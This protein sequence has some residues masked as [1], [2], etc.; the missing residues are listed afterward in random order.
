[1]RL[2]LNT[3]SGGPLTCAPS[4][5]VTIAPLADDEVRR[6]VACHRLRDAF[7]ADNSTLSDLGDEE[8]LELVKVPEDR[9]LADTSTSLPAAP[10]LQ[11]DTISVPMSIKR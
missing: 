4:T 8:M 9:W 6:A 5:P 7:V 2:S 3:V 10:S 11:A 1:M